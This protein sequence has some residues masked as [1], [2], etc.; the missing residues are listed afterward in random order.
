MISS[1]LCG[2]NTFGSDFI[3]YKKTVHSYW[4]DTGQLLFC[5]LYCSPL[6]H[7]LLKVFYCVITDG[8]F[9]LFFPFCSYSAFSLELHD[10]M[11]CLHAISSPPTS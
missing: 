2:K 9:L 5:L 4:R 3:P 7:T 1:A 10:I 11:F 8:A 6:L